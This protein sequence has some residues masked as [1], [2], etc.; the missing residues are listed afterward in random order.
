MP[1]PIPTSST[2]DS[3]G[4]LAVCAQ[5]HWGDPI[6]IFLVDTSGGPVTSLTGSSELDDCS[7]GHGLA[8]SPDGSRIAFESSPYTTQT[9]ATT[10]QIIN[11]DGTG[12]TDLSSALRLSPGHDLKHPVWSPDGSHLAFISVEN[13]VR[14]RRF[15]YVS[16]ADGTRLRRLGSDLAVLDSTWSADGRSIYYVPDSDGAYALHSVSLEDGVSSKV[17]ELAGGPWLTWSPDRSRFAQEDP[18]S[19]IDITDLRTLRTVRIEYPTPEPDERGYEPTI[20][21][22]R[23]WSPTGDRLALIAWYSP[24]TV[25]LYVV[26]VDGGQP[27]RLAVTYREIDTGE[28][29]WSPTGR[30]IVFASPY[31]DA[32]GCKWDAFL[33]QVNGG[34]PSQLTN[35][36]SVE[37]LP[38]WSP[39]GRR[40]AFVS[41]PQDEDHA[42]L[43]VIEAAGSKPLEVLEAHNIWGVTWSPLR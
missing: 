36:G 17:M 42:T 10:I 3:A 5:V 30:D 8:W 15:L 27:R 21:D 24:G 20:Y 38:S 1:T 6:H 16:S 26:E 28:F 13:G 37:D 35:D 7:Y 2:R 34:S 41:V 33:A 9:N 39:D 12:L 25:Y 14:D 29:A 23:D 11:I 22:V 31:C 18:K 32:A 19:G 43:F 4:V 40:L